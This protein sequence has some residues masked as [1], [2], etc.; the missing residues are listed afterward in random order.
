MLVVVQLVEQV[1]LDLDLGH[2][3]PPRLDGPLGEILLSVKTDSR[4]LDTHRKVFR[5][6]R[7]VSSLSGQVASNSE[8]AA[9][10]VTEPKARREHRRVGVVLG[11]QR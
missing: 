8:D 9:V 6:Q 3:R 2:P 5:D 10:V 11:Q 1:G 4:R 7:D